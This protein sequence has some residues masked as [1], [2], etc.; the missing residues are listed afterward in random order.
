MPD[1]SDTPPSLHFSHSSSDQEHLSTRESTPIGT[2]KDFIATNSRKHDRDRDFEPSWHHKSLDRSSSL[3]HRFESKLPP[4]SETDDLVPF[5]L[6]PSSPPDRSMDLDLSPRATAVSSSGQQ[7]SNLT[8][9]LRRAGEPPGFDHPNTYGTTNST[10]FKSNAARKESFGANMS[11]WGNGS[12]P[13]MM[14]GSNREKTRRE[15]LAGSLVGGMSWGGVS[16]GSWIRDEYASS[17]CDEWL[18]VWPDLILILNK[19]QYYYDGNFTIYATVTLLPFVV[20]S[21]ETRSELHARFLL[22]R[23]HSTEST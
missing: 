10:A 14:T 11:Q 2:P 18:H 3:L 13:I 17:F 16:V 5:P 4:T 9:A 1:S 15:S 12:K 23:Y 21:T 6:F 7:A 19:P 20:L 22:L 8:S